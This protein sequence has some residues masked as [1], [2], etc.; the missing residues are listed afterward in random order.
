[1]KISKKRLAEIMKEAENF[2]RTTEEIPKDEL[3][4]ENHI[5][6]LEVVANITIQN[7]GTAADIRRAYTMAMSLN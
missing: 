7:N 6:L 5:K 2:V 3:L 4:S 1:M